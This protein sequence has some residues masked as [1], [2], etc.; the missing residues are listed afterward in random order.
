[1]TQAQF[2]GFSPD[3]FDF[4][5]DLAR[6]N[7]R[8][9]FQ[10]NKKRYRDSVVEPMGRFIE[11][12]APRLAAIS[13]YFIADPRPHRGSMFRIYRDTRFSKDKRPYK[14]HVGCQFRHTRGRDVHAPGFYVHLEPGRVFFGG[15]VWKPDGSSL[16]KIRA[17][18]VDNPSA[19]QQAT[20]ARA[21]RR[22]FGRIQG[23]SLQRAPRGYAA[24][25]PL[26]DDLKLK[27]LFVLQEAEVGLACSRRFVP[28]VEQA[29]IQASPFMAF[30]AFALDL[31][32]GHT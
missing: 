20:N 12:L 29:F 30:L 21:F 31:P 15:G 18:I 26:I 28:V 23:Q 27:S 7:D 17:A 10:A 4:L 2:D 8:A 5:T 24:D 25:H 1:M 13:P 9:W 32:Y 22:R 16:A 3:L 19:W 14:E 11:A 6:N